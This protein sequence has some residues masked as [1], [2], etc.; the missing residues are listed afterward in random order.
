MVLSAS[1]ERFIEKCVTSSYL[2]GIFSFIVLYIS[3]RGSRDEGLGHLHRAVE[4]EYRNP[5][6][7]TS[8]A[9]RLIEIGDYTQA[10]QYLQKAVEVS[11]EYF[12]TY[13]HYAALMSKTGG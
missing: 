7:L 10:E 1:E 3:K 2:Y 11:P 12:D 4:I 8:M 9:G 13:T 6:A 5:E